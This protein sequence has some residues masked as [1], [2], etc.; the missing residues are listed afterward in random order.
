MSDNEESTKK[1]QQ[2]TLTKK[3]AHFS[4]SSVQFNKLCFQLPGSFFTSFYFGHLHL[5]LHIHLHVYKI[6]FI[7]RIVQKDFK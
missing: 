2:T 3:I 5:H 6:H 7:Y 1:R 4:G